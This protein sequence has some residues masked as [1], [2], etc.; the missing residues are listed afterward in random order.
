MDP[1]KKTK[2]Q[3]AR[4]AVNAAAVAVVAQ[5]FEAIDELAEHGKNWLKRQ[6]IQAIAPP[7]KKI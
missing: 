5:G 4:E 6:L 7:R 3:K 1:A 2:E